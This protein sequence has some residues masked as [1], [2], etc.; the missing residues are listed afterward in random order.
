MIIFRE[1]N[2]NNINYKTF[3]FMENNQFKGHNNDRRQFDNNQQVNV[4]APAT[5]STSSSI[6]NFCQSKTGKITIYSAVAAVL[7]GLCWIGGK[8]LYKKYTAKKAE[9]VAQEPAEK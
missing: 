5:T 8:K 1:I 2:K 3:K 7:A 9:E 6:K 4:V